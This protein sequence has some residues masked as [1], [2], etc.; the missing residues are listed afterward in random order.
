[1]A[2][3]D[4]PH[5]TL[6]TSYLGDGA[7]HGTIAGVARDGRGGAFSGSFGLE[8]SHGLGDARGEGELL[9]QLHVGPSL[10]WMGR[11]RDVLRN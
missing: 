1:M 4:F 5:C 3:S 2:G 9:T 7:L 11:V 6:Q 10:R 8:G